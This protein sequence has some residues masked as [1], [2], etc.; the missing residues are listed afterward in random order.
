MLLLKSKYFYASNKTSAWFF[1]FLSLQRKSDFIFNIYVS[2]I[3]CFPF[4]RGSEITEIYPRCPSS[5]LE[6]KISLQQSTL[7]IKFFI[8]SLKYSLGSTELP[9]THLRQIGQGFPKLWSDI[10]I[11]T[12]KHTNRDYFLLYKY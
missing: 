8:P 3:L 12:N 10:Q 1:I 11:R 9:N 2:W 5:C 6:A 4:Q 7:S